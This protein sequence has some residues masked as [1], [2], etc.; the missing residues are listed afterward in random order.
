MRARASWRSALAL[1]FVATWSACIRPPDPL[2]ADP[3]VVTV[4]ILLVAGESQAR[5][6]AVHPHRPKDAGPPKITAMLEG[7]AWKAP[8]SEELGLD[9]CTR[10]L[11]GTWPGP[12][13]CLGA[14][15][16]EP[17]RASPRYGIEGSAPLGSFKG[18]MTVPAAPVLIEPGDT[19]EVDAEEY[20]HVDILIR[21]RLNAEV[22]TVMANVRDAYETREDGTEAELDLRHEFP[23]LLDTADEAHTV[24]LWYAANPRRFSLYVLGIGR[25]YTKFLD[26]K[27]SFPLPEPWPTFGIEG[28]G[29]YGYF[30]GLAASRIARVWIR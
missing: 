22:G 3:D 7:P 15:L 25:N 1:A 24:T 9:A 28:E 13:R 30:D 19:L 27:G 17:V 26:H 11:D 6:L 23:L 10:A 8:F 16:P 2:G 14:P 29:V 12:V 4:L 21:Y 18:A 5:L 20:S